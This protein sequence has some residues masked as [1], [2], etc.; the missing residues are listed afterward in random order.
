MW[1]RFFSARTSGGA[2]TAGDRPQASFGA[3]I[4]ADSAAP[5]AT[6][7]EIQRCQQRLGSVLPA[8][9]RQFLTTRC[10]GGNFAGGLFHMLGAARPLR[11]DDLATWN[12][13]RD[14]KSA[15]PG[16]ELE[17]YVFFA[18][19]IFGNQFGYLPGEPDPAVRRFDIQMG[20]WLEVSPSLAHFLEKQ[21]GE[22]GVWL[23]G[24]DFLQA[25]R[26][27]GHSLEAGLQ[28]SMVI[29]ALLGGSME[30]ENLRPID[31]ATNLYVA[32]QLVTRI[33]PL[34]PGTE[35]RGLRVDDASRSVT[36]EARAPR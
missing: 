12:Q 9:L 28:L 20:E 18:D 14:W 30:P 1:S 10:N 36:F 6:P 34:P 26:S 8:A 32:G 25:Y 29:P 17:R 3:H 16:F 33:K 21:V 31:P 19:D 24:A 2:A 27:S 4:A 23:L 35:V 5:P 15:F 13:V 7:D 22:E 11:H